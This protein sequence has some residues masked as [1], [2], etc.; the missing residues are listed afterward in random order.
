[1]AT[2]NKLRANYYI[3]QVN[4]RCVYL[5]NLISKEGY[6]PDGMQKLIDMDQAK[7]VIDID[8]DEVLMSIGDLETAL[9]E[10]RK[11]IE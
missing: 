6:F 5:L 11:L 1:M 2:I 8:R 7:K 9:K 3:D 10:L 4:V